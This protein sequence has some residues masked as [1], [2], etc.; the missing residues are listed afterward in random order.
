MKEI[1][2]R[3]RDSQGS[4]AFWNRAAECVE[5]AKLLRRHTAARNPQFLLLCLAIELALKAYLRGMGSTVADLRTKF[6][7][8]IELLL[9]EAEKK[10]LQIS[11]FQ[12]GS[13]VRGDIA[14][15][16]NYFIPKDF[17]Y[18]AKSVSLSAKLSP[19]FQIAEALIQAVR[20][21][22]LTNMERHS[23]SPTAVPHDTNPTP[24]K[25]KR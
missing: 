17:T 5:A 20:K 18:T 24:R 10:G 12:N 9:G 13:L 6:G 19:L 14:V 8:D 21:S 23:D 16:A 3:T 15:A 4:F 1:P 22:C 7:H 2:S 25:R 11:E